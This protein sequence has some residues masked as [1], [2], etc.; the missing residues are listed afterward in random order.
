MHNGDPEN[1][2]PHW[3]VIV[4]GVVFFCVFILPIEE[5]I[6][7]WDKQRSTGRKYM[8]SLT[9]RFSSLDRSNSKKFFDESHLSS[10]IKRIGAK[11]VP[12]E[13]KILGIIRIDETTNMVR[14]M[15]MGGFDHTGLEVER[16]SDNT[17]QFLYRSNVLSETFGSFLLSDATLPKN[18]HARL[19]KEA[20][21]RSC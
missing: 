5:T 2:S 4:C 3:Q 10:Q 9:K 7:S 15:W 16:L 13:L 12:P 18:S 21:R 20:V 8:N 14:Y 11:S 6:L 17:F 19:A 1:G